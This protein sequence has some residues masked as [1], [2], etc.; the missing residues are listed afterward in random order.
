MTDK[1]PLTKTAIERITIPKS[2]RAVYYFE[3]VPG[4][5]LR[6][7]PTGR[8]VYFYLGKHRGRSVRETIGPTTKVTPAAAREI[9]KDYALELVKGTRPTERKQQEKRADTDAPTLQA[10][11][12][13][14]CR[15]HPVRSERTRDSEWK[16]H[17]Q[18]WKGRRLERL[19]RNM[20]RDWFR[21]L[22]EATS[23]ATANRVLARLRALYSWAN[24]EMDYEGPDPTAGIRK[25]SEKNLRR[26]RRLKADEV[27]AF[28]GA[29]DAVSEDMRDLF[30]L[31]LYTGQRAG[32]VKAMRLADLDLSG[33][34][35]LIPDTKQGEQTEVALP[36]AA[37]AI[38]DRRQKA[39]A[40]QFVFPARSKSGHL[41]TYR[42]AWQ[43][44][45]EAA[46][47][48]DLRLHDLRRSLASFLQEADVGVAVVAAQL[49]HADP[50]TTL[51]H[52][53]SLTGKKT[54]TAMDAA[55]AD[56]LK[57]AGVTQ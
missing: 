19:S 39:A 7:F 23:P 14:Y 36:L 50:Q 6:V 38:L 9:A 27:K 2:G 51:R 43:N 24:R 48:Q 57:N 52:Y 40:G 8:R 5:G 21:N 18:Q 53:T 20:V 12:D 32:N 4:L 44:L 33:G 10:V 45:C 22:T 11:W 55:L 31:A 3:A 47:I 34:L 49:G 30:L 1:I 29:L 26:K 41:E 35:W 56:I 15:W 28:F 54:R 13:H 25:H 16:R 42:K 46:G 17:I 37:A